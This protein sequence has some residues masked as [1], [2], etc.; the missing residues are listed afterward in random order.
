MGPRIAFGCILGQRRTRIFDVVPGAADRAVA[1]VGELVRERIADK[2]LQPGTEAALS[3]LRSAR[4][5]QECVEGADVVF[6]T[7]PENV[8]LKQE[9]FAEIDQYLGP[10]T[11]LSTNTSSIPSSW[12]ASST[13]CPE[14]VFN[15]N[16]ST[17]DHRKIEVMGHAGTAPETLETAVEFFREIGLMPIVVKGEVVGYATNRLWRAVKKEALKLLDAGYL[18]AED[19]DRAWML[20]WGTTIG[21]CGLMDKIGLDVVRDIEMI[22]YR[23][24]GDPSDIPPPLVHRMI[25]E[26][27]LGVKSGVG[28]YT[29]PNP[30]YQQEGWLL[31]EHSAVSRS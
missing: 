10:E 24:S 20:D 7:V 3:L 6:E 26:G 19:I 23:A 11:L 30:A 21:P 16:W 9:V 28:F 5:L 29:Y 27:K 18:T 12:L 4:T 31:G 13:R 15:A 1:R 17:P 2:R 22:F 25:A 14:R 8:E